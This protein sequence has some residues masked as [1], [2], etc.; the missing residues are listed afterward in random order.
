MNLIIPCLI[1]AVAAFADWEEVPI[2]DIKPLIE[3]PKKI[4]SKLN[5]PENTSTIIDPS[6][7]CFG[8]PMIFSTVTETPQII[9]YKINKKDTTARGFNRYNDNTNV[10][11][12][13]YGNIIEF[14]E[15]GTC[16][17]IDSLEIKKKSE[18]TCCSNNS[19]GKPECGKTTYRLLENGERENCQDYEGKPVCEYLFDKKRKSLKY[20]QC[21]YK[22]D[23]KCTKKR[24]WIENELFSIQQVDENCE[25]RHGWEK[26]KNCLR[27]WEWTCYL[28][29]REM[30]PS[31]CE[32]FP[33]WD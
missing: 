21:T 11:M 9:F 1:L 14:K 27:D 8:V 3:C 4:T 25:E 23:D 15:N 19:K 31:D 17:F 12:D 32:K 6:G 28:S 13:A 16:L 2:S 22:L 10:F 5:A 29:G 20:T 24:H 33:K 30:E 18:I 7:S 26:R